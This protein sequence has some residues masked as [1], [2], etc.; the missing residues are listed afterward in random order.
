[1]ETITIQAP[2]VYNFKKIPVI[3]YIRPILTDFSIFLAIGT[4]LLEILLRH[5]FS[6]KSQIYKFIDSK[7]KDLSTS[8]KNNQ[9]KHSKICINFISLLNNLETAESLQES[10]SWLMYYS[11]TKENS[12]L[13]STFVRLII[14][15][16]CKYLEN[17]TAK[18]LCSHYFIDIL[19]NFAKIMRIKIVLGKVFGDTEEFYS[20]DQGKYPIMYILKYESAIYLMYTDE[21][22]KLEEDND[23]DL[24]K[25]LFSQPFLYE[26]LLSP[27]PINKGIPFSK[28]GPEPLKKVPPE[29]FEIQRV[30]S[31][32]SKLDKD[33]NIFFNKTGPI[34]NYKTEVYQS[35][36]NY[37]NNDLISRRSDISILGLEKDLIAELRCSYSHC[38]GIGEAQNQIRAFAVGLKETLSLQ[39]NLE[40]KKKIYE[41]FRQGLTFTN[42]VLGTVIDIEIANISNLVII[43]SKVY[44]F[45]IDNIEHVG[46]EFK[47]LM[48]EKFE[49]PQG[50]STDFMIIKILSKLFNV[51]S[52]IISQND[53]GSSYDFNR[54]QMNGS[55]ENFRPTLHFISLKNYQSYR[56]HFLITNT[57]QFEDRFDLLENIKNPI[58]VFINPLQTADISVNKVDVKKEKFIEYITNV[59]KLQSLVIVQFSAS[60]KKKKPLILPRDMIKT[61]LE[62]LKTFRNQDCKNFEQK[63]SFS[64]SAVFN[65][66]CDD[67][68][69][70]CKC[71]K[72][73]YPNLFNTCGCTFHT[74]CFE[75]YFTEI[76]YNIPE[77]SIENVYLDCSFCEKKYKLS[78]FLISKYGQVFKKMCETVIE[79]QLTCSRCKNKKKIIEIKQHSGSCDEYYCFECLAIIG[80]V[81]GGYLCSCGAQVNVDIKDQLKSC[82]VC[83]EKRLLF[84]FLPVEESVYGIVCKKCWFLDLIIEKNRKLICSNNIANVQAC[85]N[86]ELVFCDFCR[87]T[88]YK[89]FSDFYCPNNC[90]LCFLHHNEKNCGKCKEPMVFKQKEW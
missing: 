50:L 60:F 15:N 46:D 6:R 44:K 57:H 43:L 27:Q 48:H 55:V 30:P 42:L 52:I 68:I 80:I 66:N 59:S 86:K 3:A 74:K 34:K 4:G 88:Y 16:E 87:Q 65:F 56:F 64:A 79:K 7:L 25:V 63:Y 36:D 13:L 77:N 33:Q 41:K 28:S 23:L 71:C 45:A 29:V 26:N 62:K 70:Y 67:F 89:P 75:E 54:I 20:K 10:L 85:L 35:I 21:M 78:L 84:N 24:E 2:I 40:A 39:T 1:M 73:P 76:C 61:L 22:R 81:K 5:R 53:L 19:E 82:R 51:T 69:L 31:N 14:Q 32:L 49:V 12:E 17:K 90:C 47:D 11:N 37:Y 18:D 9:A 58:K 72:S 38:I 83:K 8:I